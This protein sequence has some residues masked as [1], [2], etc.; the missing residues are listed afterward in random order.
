[1]LAA[2]SLGNESINLRVPLSCVDNLDQ[3]A[4]AWLRRAYEENS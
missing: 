1:V 4:L 3:E 2:R